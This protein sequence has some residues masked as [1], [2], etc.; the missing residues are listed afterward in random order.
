M[1]VFV[2][3][4]IAEQIDT[5]QFYE[6]PINDDITASLWIDSG[7][8][9]V[10]VNNFKISNYNLDMEFV[11]PSDTLFSFLETNSIKN[12]T[13]YKEK[14]KSPALEFENLNIASKSFKMSNGIHVC[15]LKAQLDN[16]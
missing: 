8:V 13:F 9:V 12:V 16:K 2:S 14:E 10:V 3:N 11:C 1:T 5:G 15:N 4:E 6:N 7:P